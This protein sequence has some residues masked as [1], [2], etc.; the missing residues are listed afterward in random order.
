MALYLFLNLNLNDTSPHSGIVIK[1]ENMSYRVAVHHA[2]LILSLYGKAIK[3][4]RDLFDAP[5]VS[6]ALLLQ[7]NWSVSVYQYN[8]QF[9]LFHH[10]IE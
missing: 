1:Y 5:D 7:F 2:H 4:T 6:C 3:Y 8:F 10:A 9:H